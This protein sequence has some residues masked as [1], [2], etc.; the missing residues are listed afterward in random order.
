LSLAFD[1]IGFTW[2]LTG[3]LLWLF[4]AEAPRIAFDGIMV[5]GSFSCGG[6]VG[7]R[8]RG[9]IGLVSPL[10]PG[11]NQC[12]GDCCAGEIAWPRGR[13]YVEWSVQCAL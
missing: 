7:R 4:G 13:E 9:M 1:R 8:R 11:P 3:L 2:A 12:R 5:D 6:F 10:K